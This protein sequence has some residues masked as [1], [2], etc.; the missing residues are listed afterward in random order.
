MSV[1][2]PIKS[3][4]VPVNDIAALD[5]LFRESH[6]HPVILFKHSV[7]CSISA[8]AFDEMKHYPGRVE[9]VTVQSARN[10]ADEI[11]T[12]TG[13]RHESPQVILL[14]GGEPVWQVSHWKI[15]ADAVTAAV[16]EK[17]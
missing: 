5:E 11:E 12:R 3:E 14:V 7:T 10:V 16:N 6:E 9:L 2:Q 1:I 4:F 13:I 15:K 8:D 17:R